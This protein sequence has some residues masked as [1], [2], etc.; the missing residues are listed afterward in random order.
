MTKTYGDSLANSW[1]SPPM[2]E[3]PKIPSVPC[4]KHHLLKNTVRQKAH[5]KCDCVLHGFW[6][7]LTS[8]VKDKT[9]ENMGVSNSRSAENRVPKEIKC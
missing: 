3:G 9:K 2:F 1:A 5:T 7:Q 8:A 6:R 4:F